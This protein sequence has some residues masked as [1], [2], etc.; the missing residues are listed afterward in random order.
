MFALLHLLTLGLSATSAQTQQSAPFRSSMR[1]MSPTSRALARLQMR[2]LRLQVPG[3]RSRE[4][5]LPHASQR[6]ICTRAEAGTAGEGGATKKQKV[7]FV[8]LGNICRSPTAEAVFKKVTM[9]NGE[10]ANFDIDSCGTGGGLDSWFKYDPP[11]SYHEGDDADPRMMRVRIRPLL[12]VISASPGCS[13]TAV[14]AVAPAGIPGTNVE[15]TFI[16][17][18]PDGVQRRHIGEIIRRF[19]NK[20]FK[21]VAI[22]KK[23]YNHHRRCLLRCLYLAGEYPSLAEKKTRMMMD[24]T[25]DEA[26][27]GTAVPDPYYGGP[28]NVPVAALV[29]HGFDTVLD[30]LEDACVGFLKAVAPK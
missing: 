20:G 19:E 18:K 25:S 27:K 17:I 28:Q 11:Q 14:H 13:R 4:G 10:S 7:L 3:A 29:P 16:A 24:Y 8:C 9:D 1:S 5:V 30:L 21:L 15:R 6:V 23:D 26:R 2:H 22:F 12:D